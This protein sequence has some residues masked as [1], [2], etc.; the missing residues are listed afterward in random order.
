MI[1]KHLVIGV[2]FTV[3]PGLMA[4]EIVGASSVV[5]W[6]RI[7]CSPGKQTISICMDWANYSH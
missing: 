5:E 3:N 6:A 7:W 4:V 2:E 1:P